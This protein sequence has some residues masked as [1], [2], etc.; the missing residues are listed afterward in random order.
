MHIGIGGVHI[1]PL[2]PR[3][4]QKR[5]VARAVDLGEDGGAVHI[6]FA[7]FVAVGLEGLLDEGGARRRLKAG[8][9][10]PTEKLVDRRV[11]GVLGGEEGDHRL[12][13][14]AL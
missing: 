2:L 12:S 14:L 9:A 4:L 3:G 8:H 5:Q 7:Q 10:L 11:A 1:Q 6:W 13:L